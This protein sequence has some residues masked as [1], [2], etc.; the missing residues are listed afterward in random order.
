MH[1]SQVEA[2]GRT[3]LALISILYA[4]TPLWWLVGVKPWIIQLTLAFVFLALADKLRYPLVSRLLLLFFVVYIFSLVHSLYVARPVRVLGSFVNLSVWFGGFVIITFIH[5]SY[6]MDRSV[7]TV[8]RGLLFV[9]SLSSII[10][11]WG[12]F[13]YLHGHY[14]VVV[15]SPGL[16]LYPRSIV[17][18][19]EILNDTLQIMAVRP[20]FTVFGVLPRSAGFFAYANALALASV[21]ALPFVFD[22]RVIRSVKSRALFSVATVVTLVGS[23]SRGTLVSLLGCGTIT[24]LLREYFRSGRYSLKRLVIGFVSVTAVLAVGFEGYNMAQ[25]FEEYRP[26]ST[27]LPQI[28]A[29]ID[30]LHS[31]LDWIIGIGYKPR[32]NGLEHSFPVGSH[33]TIAGTLMK[34]GVVGLSLLML[35]WLAIARRWLDS[36]RLS[37]VNAAHLPSLLWGIC[38]MTGLFWQIFEDLD[39]PPMAAFA[40]FLMLGLFLAGHDLSEG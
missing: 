10:V 37:V 11:L 38:A 34:T 7:R 18:H 15:M 3:P 35:I 22:R 16:E 27:R 29:A 28:E 6:S 40:Y 24:F 8:G 33:S 4:L 9:V 36:I 14:L 30:A 12:W 1:E 20:D 23:G 2:N 39:A 17:D 26:G 5:N 31:P 21:A 13:N 19:S 32:P 25:D